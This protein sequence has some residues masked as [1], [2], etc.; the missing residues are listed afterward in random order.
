[1]F[2]TP[3]FSVQVED[4]E[5]DYT[6]IKNDMLSVESRD[7]SE[8][9]SSTM[10]SPPTKDGC[11]EAP[12]TTATDVE[13][14]EAFAPYDSDSSPARP[15]VLSFG[16]AKDAEEPF[17]LEMAL[18][19]TLG[20]VVVAFLVFI[21]ARLF[22]AWPSQSLEEAIDAE[23]AASDSAG[24]EVAENLFKGLVLSH[25][26]IGSQLQILHPKVILTG[27]VHIIASIHQFVRNLIGGATHN[28]AE[29]F[30]RKG[31]ADE[32]NLRLPDPPKMEGNNK[33]R[34]G[35][36]LNPRKFL[37]RPGKRKVNPVVG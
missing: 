16:D 37:R 15:R 13:T 26:D 32:D 11:K 36:F 9:S 10:E 5:E 28:F 17:G 23:D 20:C 30:H 2:C 33:E 8:T 3:F 29:R 6:T 35:G 34:V 14:P 24:E 12:G 22:A 18:Q 25:G 31:R 21:V 27:G 7:F 1:M 4:E 19:S